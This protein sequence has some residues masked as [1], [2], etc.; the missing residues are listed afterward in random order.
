MYLTLSDG[1]DVLPPSAEASDEP[2]AHRR[3]NCRVTKFL[4][5][6]ITNN[7][8]IPLSKWG[9]THFGLSTITQSQYFW[10]NTSFD[11][12][13]T[14]KTNPGKM[15]T[16]GHLWLKFCWTAKNRHISI[17]GLFDLLILKVQNPQWVFPLS[18]KSITSYDA[19][20]LRRV[21][22]LLTLTC[23][24]LTS[25]AHRLSDV[26][27][28]TSTKLDSCRNCSTNVTYVSRHLASGVCSWSAPCVWVGWEKAVE[29]LL[30]TV[31]G[32][33]Y[34]DWLFHNRSL[35]MMTMMTIM[36]VIIL[37]FVRIFC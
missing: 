36:I 22:D 37:T 7:W 1:E 24:L 23:D 13:M 14:S 5:E 30:L 15:N 21:C 4:S 8:T 20:L 18:F 10:D 3:I 6:V 29:R 35:K 2:N 32:N 9:P 12:T 31:H 34:S 11:I 25:Q 27:W 26:T 28:S 19:L 33:K 17:S 16:K